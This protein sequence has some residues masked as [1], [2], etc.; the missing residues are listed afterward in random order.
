[1]AGSFGVVPSRPARGEG[2]GDLAVSDF[3]TLLN[4]IRV[5]VGD[6]ELTSFA[7]L[8]LL[9]RFEDVAI[10][11]INTRHCKLALRILRFLI[12]SDDA[13]VLY[14]R[15]AEAFRILDPRKSQVAVTAALPELFNVSLHSTDHHV[16]A[17]I[18]NEII[19][20]DK[21]LSN[22]HH[23]CKSERSVLGDVGDFYAPALAIANGSLD[24]VAVGVADD[25]D[26]LDPCIDRRLD[27]VVKDRLVG[28]RDEMLVLRVGEGTKARA[29]SAAGDKCFQCGLLG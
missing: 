11:N 1:M 23:V 3:V 5:C 21:L 6:F 29:P 15:H 16:V 26:L 27:S 19:L 8:D 12:H 24:F 14:F 20:A 25:A 10:I 22:L 4:E 17:E 18:E 9:H 28:D 2:A 7:R 13:A